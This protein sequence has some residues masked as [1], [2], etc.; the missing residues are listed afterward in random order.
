MQ[1]ARVVFLNNKS[2]GAADLLWPRLPPLRLAG[3]REVA[4][5]FVFLQAHHFN[6]TADYA[7]ETAFAQDDRTLLRFGGNRLANEVT[8]EAADHNVLAKFGNFSIEQIFD[9]DVGIFDEALFEQTDRAVEL[10]E[11]SVD[12]FF[13]HVFG[14]AFDL[15][16]INLALGLDQFSGHILA[17]DV[18]RVRGRDMQC[19]VFNE[20]AE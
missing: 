8:G 17:A 11:F 4:L 7:D 15:R 13:S 14:L 1:S 10:V 16:L 19:D 9:R 18:K 2:R 5:R 6:L 3:L 12:N 20:P